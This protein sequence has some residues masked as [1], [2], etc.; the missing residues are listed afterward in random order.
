MAGQAFHTTDAEKIK[1]L[2]SDF[3]LFSTQNYHFH[4]SDH[5]VKQKSHLLNAIA[6]LKEFPNRCSIAPE[7]PVIG[8]EIRQ[9][10]VGKQ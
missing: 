6:S 7:A 1:I 8:R 4:V 2:M 10:W 3:D 5:Y 9:L